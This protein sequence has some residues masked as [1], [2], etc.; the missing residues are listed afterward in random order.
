MTNWAKVRLARA[1]VRNITSCRSMTG[2]PLNQYCTMPSGWPTPL[3]T[4]FIWKYASTW[5]QSPLYP[6]LGLK[7]DRPTPVELLVVVRPARGA[8]RE[9]VLLHDPVAAAHGPILRDANQVHRDRPVAQVDRQV[10]LQ[11]HPRGPRAV[12]EV[13]LDVGRE[14]IVGQGGILPVEVAEHV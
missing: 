13:G 12:D 7:R 2:T 6:A 9:E 14:P 4:L 8:L 10:V 1:P 3:T 11:R 5:F